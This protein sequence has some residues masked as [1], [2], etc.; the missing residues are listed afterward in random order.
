MYLDVKRTGSHLLTEYRMRVVSLGD[1]L[2]GVGDTY[3]VQADLHPTKV[4]QVRREVVLGY[5]DKGV[6][7]L[8]DVMP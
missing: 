3:F 8:A 7:P 1:G 6:L 2:A 5:S 4:L